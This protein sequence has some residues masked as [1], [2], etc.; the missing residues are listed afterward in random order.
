MPAP[1]VLLCALA[2]TA[3]QI[4]TM[5]FDGSQPGLVDFV[6]TPDGADAYQFTS[7]GPSMTAVPL[8]TDTGGNLRA[9]FVPTQGAADQDTETCATWSQRTGDIVQMGA[10][11]RV[12]GGGE[13][14]GERRGSVTKKRK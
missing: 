13:G 2:L 5:T 14:A 11:L 10:A 9:V 8:V 12:R 6:L 1:A 7:N 4:R 3:C